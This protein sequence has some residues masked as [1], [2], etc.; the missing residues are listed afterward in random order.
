MHK[1]LDKAVER[2]KL[3]LQKKDEP[4]PCAKAGIG[5]TIYTKKI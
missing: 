2:L 1:S 5:R 3:A 4:K